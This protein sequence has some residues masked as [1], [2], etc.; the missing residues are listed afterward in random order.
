MYN[1]II[2]HVPHSSREIPPDVRD[3][4]L[5]G[6]EQ[7]ELELLKMTDAYTDEIISPGTYEVIVAPVSR[8]VVDVERFRDDQFEGMAKIGMGAVYTKTQDGNQLRKF[9]AKERDSLL[10]R[11]YDPHHEALDSLTRSVLAEHGRVLIFDLHSFPGSPLPYEQNVSSIRPEICI[12]TDSFHTPRDLAGRCRDFFDKHGFSVAENTP[13]AGSLVPAAFYKKS[14]E[15]TSIMI[16]IRRDL[17][18]NERSG[19]KLPAVDH[20][21]ETI[22]DLISIESH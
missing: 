10:M 18:M 21:F 12:G 9:D 15:I 7:L 8:L 11:Y 19:E 16:E 17:I 13:F 6:D 3:N 22:R 1:K 2:I 4:I 20:I 14:Y 5:L